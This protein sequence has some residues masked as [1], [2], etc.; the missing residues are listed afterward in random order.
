MT[1]KYNHEYELR[2]G[3]RIL[4]PIGKMSFN[5]QVVA[6]KNGNVHTID[7]EKSS[8]FI[9]KIEDVDSWIQFVNYDSS[10]IH[11]FDVL[12]EVQSGTTVNSINFGDGS[13]KYHQLQFDPLTDSNTILPYI[14]WPYLIPLREKDR[15]GGNSTL[16]TIRYGTHFLVED[17]L[18]A[19]FAIVSYKWYK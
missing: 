10:L 2:E 6:S 1:T 7:L 13:N 17:S 9:V 11:R 4:D 8:N 14:V 19:A 18:E 16:L 15:T 12:I 3:K 5:E